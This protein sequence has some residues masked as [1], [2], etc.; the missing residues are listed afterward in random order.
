MAKPVRLTQA[1]IDENIGRGY[2]DRTSISDILKR[3]A[4]MYP[5]K[6]AVVDSRARLTWSELDRVVNAVAVGLLDNGMKRDQAIVAQLPT[7]V[8]SLILLLACHRAGIICCF[9]PMTFRRNEM[10]HVLKKL[11]AT[12]VVT[13]LVLRNTH[14]FNMIKDIAPDLPH[15]NY[16]F[17]VGDEVPQGA[18][19]FEALTETS[20]EEKDPDEYLRAYAF[21]PFEVSI[22]MLSSGTTGKPKCIEHT[23]AS[24]K[25]AGWGV[26]ERSK[27][28]QED[29]VGNIAP[30]SGGPGLQN[31]WGAIQLG[32]RVCL[33]ERFTPGGVLRLIQR[34][35]ITY[36]GAVPAQ[37]IR[38][39]KES[40]LRRY[41][42]SS[43]RV[44]RTGAAAFDASMAREPPIR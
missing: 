12:A 8:T 26:V 14:Y 41:D 37:I 32:A 13:P 36:L 1:M 7:S 34:E 6:E 28:T 20:I 10:R 16:L 44:V 30:L 29:V 21:S 24:S 27:L 31:W 18:V 9:S 33:L 35:R 2:W 3:N 19:S 25:A 38:I 15:L 11:Q 17:V 23:G 40:D 39:L 43:L 42:L 22:V 5:D 4:E